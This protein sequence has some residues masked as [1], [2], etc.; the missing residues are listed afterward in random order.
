MADRWMDERDRQWRERDWRRNERLSRGGGE[1][2]RQGDDRREDY[3]GDY[4]GS[5][6]GERSF[7]PRDPYARGQSPYPSDQARFGGADY[8]RPESAQR[9]EGEISGQAR[10]GPWQGYQNQAPNERSGYQA[11]HGGDYSRHEGRSPNYRDEQDRRRERHEADRRRGPYG[12][13]DYARNALHQSVSNFAGHYDESRDPSRHR[14]GPGGQWPQDDT[15]AEQD[16][17]HSGGRNFFERATNKLSSWFGYEEDDRGMAAR[18]QHRGRGPQGYKRSDER[19][20]DDVHERLTDDPWVDA[21]DIQVSVSAGEVT[22]SGTVE[23]RESK[24]RAERI[25]EDLSGVHHVQNN[26]RVQ[27]ANPIRDPGRGFGDSANAAQM[28][29]AEVHPTDND[30]TAQRLATTMG[31]DPTLGQHQERTSTGRKTDS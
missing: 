23:D 1:D 17:G 27:K 31:A 4:G 24:H 13:G 30:P 14:Q 10:G 3:R 19:I 6:Y 12:G 26:L 2:Y 18:G 16:R 20:A 21:S 22:L 7:E 25:V 5:D 8:T 15:R 28:R 9:Y 29:Q 11:R